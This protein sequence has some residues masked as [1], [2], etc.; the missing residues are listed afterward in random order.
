M[1]KINHY[2][3]RGIASSNYHQQKLYPQ[4]TKD[5]TK[6]LCTPN[7][8]FMPFHSESLHHLRS[9]PNLRPTGKS[10]LLS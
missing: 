6:R 3:L 1:G 10:L 5:P 8:A 2:V 9:S 4:T 7:M